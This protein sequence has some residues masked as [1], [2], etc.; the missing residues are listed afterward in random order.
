LKDIEG[1]ENDIFNLIFG[2]VF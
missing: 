2:N 1:S